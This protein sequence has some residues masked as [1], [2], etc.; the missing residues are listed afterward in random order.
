MPLPG[1]LH[2]RRFGFGAC[3]EPHDLHSH[4]AHTGGRCPYGGVSAAPNG[5]RIPPLAITRGPLRCAHGKRFQRRA[6]RR[7]RLARRGQHMIKQPELLERVDT[8]RTIGE[9]LRAAA[10]GEG[11]TVALL[12]TPGIGKTAMLGWAAALASSRGF[13]V[14]QALA[15]PM[16][17]GLPFG[18]LGQAIVALGG[19]PVEDVA[20]LARAGGQS[21]RFYRTL[22]WLGERPRP[23]R[24][25]SRSTTCTGPI[26]THSSCSASSAAGSPACACWSSAR[27]GRSRRRPACSSR[28][29]PPA[30]ARR[31]S[32]SSR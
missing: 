26:P 2:M 4:T 9:A 21:A 8:E 15:S 32:H 10:R 30:G 6:A 25:S 24:C 28:S 18:L 5:G 17:R 29:W 13:A 12:G 31:R 7:A 14:A 19:N 16:E 1:K 23:S 11:S 22:R 20:E 3:T 27:C